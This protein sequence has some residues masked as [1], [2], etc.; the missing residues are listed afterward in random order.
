[1]A[2][3]RRLWQSMPLASIPGREVDIMKKGLTLVE[4]L[5][6]ITI[7]T[8][9]FLGGL[10][11]FAKCIILNESNRNLMIAVS[12]AQ[13]VMEE[14]LEEVKDQTTLLSLRTKI[15]DGVTWCWE[16]DSDFPVTL[17]RLANETVEIC[18][19]NSTSP[20]G[21]CCPSGC[22]C[23]DEDPLRIRVTSSWDDRG[24]RSREIDLETFITV[25]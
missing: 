10:A 25:P 5:I 24:G 23:P 1:M 19:Y 17:Q 6:G 13:F 15:D 18:C 16:E 9:A 8:F 2:R 22:S 21:W 12:H 4:L 3:S 14:V 11:L 20:A 7:L